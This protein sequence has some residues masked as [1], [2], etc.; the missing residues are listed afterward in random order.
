MHYTLDR[1]DY[2]E[3]PTISE[4]TAKAI[5]LLQKGSQGYFLMVEGA[6]IDNAHHKN[7]AAN[8][9]HETIAMAE[10]VKAADDLT[11]NQN[12]LLLG[13]VANKGTTRIDLRNFLH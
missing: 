13:T 12:T 5:R 4:M 9:L 10:A 7:N 3:E 1:G 2:P 11:E 6:L 8:A